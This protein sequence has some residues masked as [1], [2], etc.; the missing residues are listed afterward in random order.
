MARVVAISRIVE[1]Q[2]QVAI[3]VGAALDRLARPPPLVPIYYRQRTGGEIK[4]LPRETPAWRSWGTVEL[5]GIGVR[6]SPSAACLPGAVELDFSNASSTENR[7]ITAVRR[8]VRY[9]SS[10]TPAEGLMRG[11][12]P[13]IEN[14]MDHRLDGDRGESLPADQTATSGRTSPRRSPITNDCPAERL[15]LRQ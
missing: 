15:T 13:A 14:E 6:M 2:P 1:K 7:A 10:S 3:T 9:E 4:K 11:D 12:L 8:Q 5:P